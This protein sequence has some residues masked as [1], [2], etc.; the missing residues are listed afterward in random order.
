MMIMALISA[1]SLNQTQ[2]QVLCVVYRR[3][4]N[5]SASQSPF[6]WKSF[7]HTIDPYKYYNQS[8]THTWAS[9]QHQHTP[10]T[11]THTSQTQRLQQCVCVCITELCI[12]NRRRGGAV[13]SFLSD[14]AS[15]VLLFRSDNEEHDQPEH[16]WNT[17]RLKAVYGT[18]IHLVN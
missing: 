13:N 1:L 10:D 7:S 3:D 16:L 18:I 12:N 6:I 2:S 11:H 9:V 15:A 5:S 14:G 17:D 8:L 4:I